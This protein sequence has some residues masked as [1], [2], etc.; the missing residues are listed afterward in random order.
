MQLLSLQ[1]DFAIYVVNLFSIP[2]CSKV[3]SLEH[4]DMRWLLK[5]YCGVELN[6]LGSRADWR[7]ACGREVI[8][9]CVR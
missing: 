9:E 1:R 7:W 6:L 4:D 3:L 8:I 5:Q 2:Q